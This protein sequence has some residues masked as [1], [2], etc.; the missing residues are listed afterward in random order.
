MIATIYLPISYL[1]MWLECWYL[2]TIIQLR[3]HHLQQN[4]RLDLPEP[5]FWCSAIK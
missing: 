2:Y 5:Q 4:Q 1:H 3:N